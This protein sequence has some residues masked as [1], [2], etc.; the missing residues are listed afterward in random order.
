[1]VENGMGPKLRLEGDEERRREVLQKEGR[2]DETRLQQEGG[3]PG[4]LT[5]L[6][7]TVTRER[8]RRPSCR[9]D[10]A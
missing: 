6:N 3:L 10:Y 2:P 1:M 4:D 7:V 8:P 9:L 5:G